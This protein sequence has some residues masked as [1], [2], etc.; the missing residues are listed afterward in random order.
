MSIGNASGTLRAAL[1]A[2][3]T[4]EDS[5]VDALKNWVDTH[6]DAPNTATVNALNSVKTSFDNVKTSLQ[7]LF[8]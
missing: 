8:Q 2:L 4:A 7:N 5:L 3:M 1:D 6:G